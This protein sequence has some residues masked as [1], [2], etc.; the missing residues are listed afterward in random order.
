MTD[1]ELLEM[2]FKAM[3]SVNSYDS[4][5]G[6]YKGCF[7]LEIKILR[8][9]LD[10]PWVKTY[11]GGKPN[12]TEPKEWV[13]LTDDEADVLIVNAGF[14]K[15]DLLRLG[16]LIAELTIDVEEKLKEKNAKK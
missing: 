7:D 10:E 11:S 8:T 1:R 15:E 13:G 3:D 2:A 6:A 14:T 4:S 5:N 9:R 12:Y 16:S